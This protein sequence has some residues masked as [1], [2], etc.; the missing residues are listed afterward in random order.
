MEKPRVVIIG[1]GGHGCVMLDVIRVQGKTEVVGFLDD[2]EQLWGQVVAGVEV[3]GPAEPT[4]ELLERNITHFVVAIGDNKIRAAKYE[5]FVDCGLKP[6]S[7]VHPSAVIA[8]SAEISEGVQVVAGVIVNPWAKV[9]P[10]AILNTA[11][12]VDHHCEIGE[13]AFIGPGV[14]LG[15]AV[16]VGAMAFLGIGV[17]VLPGIQIGERAVVGAGAV[18]TKDVPPGTVV[19]GIP[20]RVVRMVDD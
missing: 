20:A 2:R 3:I 6:W 5:A 7:A 1:A 4:A 19:V 11:C 18:V 13:H 14:H 8:E 17:S 16:K 15:G 12:T 9:G 10:D